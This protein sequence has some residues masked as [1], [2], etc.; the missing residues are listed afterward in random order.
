MPPTNPQMTAAA[1]PTSV[2]TSSVVTGSNMAYT[3][4]P[5]EN[6]APVA[7]TEGISGFQETFAGSSID[8]SADPSVQV[9]ESVQVGWPFFVLFFVFIFLRNVGLHVAVV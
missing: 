5:R 3:L 4:S 2:M 1:L 8:P 9:S 7:G 6:P